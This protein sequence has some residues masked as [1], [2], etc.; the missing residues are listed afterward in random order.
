MWGAFPALVGY[1]PHLL[2]LEVCRSLFQ[3]DDLP[4]FQV[5]HTLRGRLIMNCIP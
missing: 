5:P 2:N 4:V 1:F 3:L